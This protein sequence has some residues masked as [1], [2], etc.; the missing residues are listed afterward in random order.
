MGVERSGGFHRYLAGLLSKTWLVECEDEEEPGV[1]GDHWVSA[2]DNNLTDSVDWNNL[3]RRKH[4]RKDGGKDKFYFGIVESENAKNKMTL[5]G[6]LVPV[7][8]NGYAALHC[9]HKF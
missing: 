9:S 8:A 2:L 6:H 7:H 1:K 3:G 4:F 5:S